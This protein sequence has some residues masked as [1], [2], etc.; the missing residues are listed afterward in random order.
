M[1]GIL[2]NE[3]TEAKCR[4]YRQLL[5]KVGEF[6]FLAPKNAAELVRPLSSAAVAA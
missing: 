1:T 3:R 4:L 2:S 6:F 5:P